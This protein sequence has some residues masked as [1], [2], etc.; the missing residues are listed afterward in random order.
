MAYR[1]LPIA[2]ELLKNPHIS[3]RLGQSLSQN[4]LASLYL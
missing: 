3:P 1:L 4:R 2:L